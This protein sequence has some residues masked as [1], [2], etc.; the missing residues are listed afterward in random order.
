MASFNM[1]SIESTASNDG[2]TDV[3][4]KDITS[5]RIFDMIV[6]KELE[7]KRTPIG[8]RTVINHI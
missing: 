1:N 2:S 7:M 5:I 3:I 4:H 6:L 8:T